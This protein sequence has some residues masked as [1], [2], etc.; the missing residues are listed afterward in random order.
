MNKLAWQVSMPFLGYQDNFI[1]F[2]FFSRK[3]FTR[4]KSTKNTK[5]TQAT[6]TQ[7]F[8]IR[9]KSKKSTKKRK[10]KQATYTQTLYTRIKSTKSTKRQT[11]DFLSL[12]RFYCASKSKHK[13]HI[14]M[15]KNANKRISDFLPLR[16]FLSA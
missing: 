9:T 6:F 4:T 14:K 12:R 3:Y 1:Y 7:M 5:R 13:K 10:R 11:S 2:F 16:C 8:F 15:H